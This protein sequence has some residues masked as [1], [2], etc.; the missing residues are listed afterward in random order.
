MVLEQ[1]ADLGTGYLLNG[2]LTW[3]DPKVWITAGGPYDIVL[4]DASGQVLP[5]E[6]YID[7]SRKEYDPAKIYPFS[8]QTQG[9]GNGALT[10][11]LDRVS[12]YQS[13]DIP[14][15]VDLGENIQAG[16]VWELNREF[17]FHGDKFTIV[18][19]TAD[20]ARTELALSFVIETTGNIT[21]AAVS[22]TVVMTDP[23]QAG[24]PVG[25]G[26][27]GWRWWWRGG[28]RG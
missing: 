26:R 17:D 14:F 27:G 20:A 24:A 25:G 6:P 7:L 23:I 19:V 5:M 2:Y 11:T 16:Q 9:K 18:S 3:T 8:Y 12:V 15:E 10:L 28:W 1:V 13:L 21:A 4:K 22:D